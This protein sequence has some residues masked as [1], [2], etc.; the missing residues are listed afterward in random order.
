VVGWVEM[1]M[2]ALVGDVD[3]YYADIHVVADAVVVAVVDFEVLVVEVVHVVFP[4]VAD[5]AVERAAAGYA[6]AAAA[7]VVE[8][9]AAA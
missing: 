6:A 1:E 3:D 9:A 8:R 7:A 2:V 5:I 4:F